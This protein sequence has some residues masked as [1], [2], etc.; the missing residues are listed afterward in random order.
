MVAVAGGRLIAVPFVRRG[1]VTKERLASAARDER[2]LAD[3]RR[4]VAGRAHEARVLVVGDRKA[5]DEELAD[6]DAVHRPLVLFHIGGAHEE[7]AARNSSDV[8][9][10]RSAHRRSGAAVASAHGVWS[11]LKASQYSPGLQAD[12]FTENGRVTP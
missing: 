6:E 12:R 3:G 7:I 11:H 5:A 4:A 10:G 1:H 2:Q 9:R 8:R